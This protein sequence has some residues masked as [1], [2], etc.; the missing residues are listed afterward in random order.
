ML[1]LRHHARGPPKARQSFVAPY[2][3]KKNELFHKLSVL[4]MSH[5]RKGT[6]MQHFHLL[7]HLTELAGKDGQ[8]AQILVGNSV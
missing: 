4:I 8:L 1:A 7:S 5:I 6:D 3:P 2:D